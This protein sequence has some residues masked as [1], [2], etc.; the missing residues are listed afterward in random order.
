MHGPFSN[1]LDAVAD[2]LKSMLDRAHVLLLKMMLIVKL[3]V[4]QR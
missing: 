4:T 2:V 1:V 3:G